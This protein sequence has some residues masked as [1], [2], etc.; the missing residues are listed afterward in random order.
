MN[1][2]G[3]NQ[4]EGRGLD[5]NSTRRKGNGSQGRALSGERKKGGLQSVLIFTFKPY[6]NSDA[7]TATE[8]LFFR[9]DKN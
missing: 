8:I 5:V 2:K 3:G 1:P 6:V 7:S 4:G 9:E